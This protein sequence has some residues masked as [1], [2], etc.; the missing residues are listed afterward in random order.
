MREFRAPTTQLPSTNSLR[1][2]ALHMNAR[3][4]LMKEERLEQ[5]ADHLNAIARATAVDE[6]KL[7]RTAEA[8]VHLG[9]GK[10]YGNS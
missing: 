1:V 2:H 3:A 8:L 5:K 4:N 7:P 10:E 6:A 9:A